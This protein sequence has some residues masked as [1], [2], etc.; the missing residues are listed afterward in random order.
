MRS[1][2]AIAS[3]PAC[4]AGSETRAG[5]VGRRS[6]YGTGWVLYTGKPVTSGWPVA[7]KKGDRTFHTILGMAMPP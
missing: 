5:L 1:R 3:P 2:V 7:L 6:S 4:S